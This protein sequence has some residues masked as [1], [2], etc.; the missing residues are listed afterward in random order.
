MSMGAIREYTAAY[1]RR[2]TIREQ[3]HEPEQRLREEAAAA[4]A[5]LRESV[6][7]LEGEAWSVSDD[8]YVRRQTV[9]SQRVVSPEALV[10]AVGRIDGTQ[11]TQLYARKV[12]AGAAA[13]PRTR[14]L[15]WW[16]CAVGG[17]R[18]EAVRPSVTVRLLPAA[19]VP[20]GVGAGAVA[21]PPALEAAAL[22]LHEARRR[23]QRHTAETHRLCDEVELSGEAAAIRDLGDDTA[24]VQVRMA[25]GTR[26]AYIVR[27]RNRARRASSTPAHLNRAGTAAELYPFLGQLHAARTNEHR[28]R[29]ARELLSAAREVGS[30]N[31]RTLDFRAVSG[32]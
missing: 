4:A 32:D 24:R 13:T 17:T 28:L 30:V 20:A 26:H 8:L 12:A 14:L 23:L 19:Q 18:R 29:V 6:D 5:A 21:A 16:E 2:R 9:Q 3:R 31:T 15:A 7:G 27:P 11:V 22:R 10:R 25:D 1:H